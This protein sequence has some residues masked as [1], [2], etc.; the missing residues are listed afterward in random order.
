MHHVSEALG[1]CLCTAL[2]KASRAVTRVYD[3]ALHPAGMTTVQ[4]AILRHIARAETVP[5][6]RLADQLVLER[7]S[8][9]RTLEPLERRGWVTVAAG[10]GKAKLALLTPA[11]A[12]VL[13]SAV[14]R[15]EGT[16]Q[17]MTEALGEARWAELR[18]LL[19]ET[20]EIAQ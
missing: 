2:R 17:R 18:T 11:G 13:D 9:Y 14:E 4:F 3:E 1:P 6:S 12:A 20:V 5:L 8:L 7:T 19:A 15:W 10:A 16:Q